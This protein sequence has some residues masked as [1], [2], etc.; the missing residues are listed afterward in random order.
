MQHSALGGWIVID[1]IRSGLWILLHLKIVQ[2]HAK[3]AQDRVAKILQL[4]QHLILHFFIF[5]VERARN[6]RF[7]FDGVHICGSNFEHLTPI[8]KSFIQIIE[9]LVGYCTT[10]K[11]FD[12]SWSQLKSFTAVFN[13]IFVALLSSAACRAVAKVNSPIVGKII[14]ERDEVECIAIR[15]GCALNVALLKQFIALLFAL[16]RGASIPGKD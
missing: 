6:A 1:T 3:F 11:G 8:F 14:I 16:R 15:L 2:A 13:N 12:V 5:G 7:L 10:H 9:C 4:A